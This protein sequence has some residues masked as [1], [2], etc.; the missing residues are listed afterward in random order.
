[1]ML[2]GIPTFVAVLV[3]A[4]RL[5]P[6]AYVAFC[7]IA[8]VPYSYIYS[9]AYRALA[10]KENPGRKPRLYLGAIAVQLIVIAWAVGLGSALI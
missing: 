10:I 9:M 2:I 4:Q 1:M 6:L 3:A 8:M 7:F 5:G